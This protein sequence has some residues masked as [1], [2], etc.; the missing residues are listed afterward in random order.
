MPASLDQFSTSQTTPLET[1]EALRFE[2][3]FQIEQSYAVQGETC[4]NHAPYIYFVDSAGS[5]RLVQGC[6]NSW[7]CRRCGQIRARKEYG[8]IV[9][10]ARQLHASG[11]LLY[12]WTL[13]CQGKEMPLE[14]AETEYLIWT[15][16][17]FTAARTKAARAGAFWCYV[18]V[19]ERQAR[20][21][22]H[23]HVIST[24]SPPDAVE[25]GVGSRL[26]NGRIATHDTL[27]SEWFRSANVRA[28]L[29][30]E[31]DLSYIQNPVAVAVYVSKYLFKDS[32]GTKFEKGWRRIRYA[33]SFPKLPEVQNEQAF[34]VVTFA[35]WQRV[36]KIGKPTRTDSEYTYYAALARLITCVLPPLDID[37]RSRI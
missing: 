13:T 28:G 32:M 2:A 17:L 21:H 18:Q 26:P 31:C 11:H 14:T 35:D 8:R 34:P 4:E 22:P 19:T 29:G 1:S 12:F 15:N 36:E 30:V 10:G 25:Y 7:T 5:A 37:V 16:R 33:Q 6:C 23:S 27:W 3:E 20:G 9:D 24:Y